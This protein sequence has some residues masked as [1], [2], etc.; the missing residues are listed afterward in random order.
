MVFKRRDRRSVWR[1][2]VESFWPKGG[3]GR[4]FSYVKHRLRRLPD[5]PHRIARG[6]MAGIMATFTPFFGF[7]F[8]TAALIAWIMRGNILAAM[9]TT[10]AGNPITF[11][12]IGA[13]SLQ[14]GTWI[15]GT[16]PVRGEPQGV[17]DSFS[18]AMGDLWHNFLAIFTPETAEWSNL[19]V[20]WR[21]VFLPYLVGGIVPGIILGLIFYY[22]SVPLLVAYQNRRKGRLKEKL[23]RLRRKNSQAPDPGSD[24][25]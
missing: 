23:D 15:L 2:V 14:I 24:P 20:F 12:F 11:P 4:A 5:P 3:W 6:I 8:V 1:L 9:L 10:F 25:N 19:F 17:I 21:E 16:P 13:I 7:H 18:R 22:V